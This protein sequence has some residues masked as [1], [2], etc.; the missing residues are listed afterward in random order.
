[1]L[2]RDYYQFHKKNLK[3]V[4]AHEIVGNYTRSETYSYFEMTPRKHPSSAS[5]PISPAVEYLLSNY[6]YENFRN[7]QKK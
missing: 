2:L 4:T 3:L 1:V 7:R 6:K 5:D